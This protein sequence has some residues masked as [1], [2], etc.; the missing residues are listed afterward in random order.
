MKPGILKL[1]AQLSSK[2]ARREISLQDPDILQETNQQMKHINLIRNPHTL[3]PLLSLSTCH[4]TSLVIIILVLSLLA[5]E[6]A[7]IVPPPAVLTIPLP[8]N[9]GP[10]PTLASFCLSSPK[11]FLSLSKR[12][13][14]ALCNE[15]STYCEPLPFS[16]EEEPPP[17]TCE[18]AM[19]VSQPMAPKPVKK[20]ARKGRRQGI[21]EAIMA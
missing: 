9:P 3:S 20:L 16:R 15:F 5:I 21:V 6:L 4:C 2:N 10:Q 7:S 11:L 17:P 1:Q 14:S 8:S 18:P 19:T 12:F 13:D